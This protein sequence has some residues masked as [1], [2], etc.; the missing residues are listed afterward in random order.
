MLTTLA[1]LHSNIDSTAGASLEARIDR[2]RLSRSDVARRVD[3]SPAAKASSKATR[4]Q[5]RSRHRV[6]RLRE[7]A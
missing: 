4:D 7:L 3:R 2:A 1:P 6:R 5:A